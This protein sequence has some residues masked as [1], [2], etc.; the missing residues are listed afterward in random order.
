[1]KEFHAS[2][3]DFMELIETLHNDFLLCPLPFDWAGKL[4]A[5]VMISANTHWHYIEHADAIDKW[6]DKQA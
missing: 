2:H 5:L 3:H 1:M 6:L 4:T